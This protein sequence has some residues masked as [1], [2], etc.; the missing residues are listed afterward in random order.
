MTDSTAEAT[1]SPLAPTLAEVTANLIRDL[2]TSIEELTSEELNARPIESG[3]S[4]GFHAW[5]VLR[6]IDNIVNFVFYRDR[7]FWVTEGLHEQLDLPRIDQ[8]TGMTDEEANALHFRSA[9]DLVSYGTGVLE[10]VQPKIE[11]MDEEFLLGT[12]QTRIAGRT[13][14]RQR[15]FSLSQVVIAHG[16]EHYGQIQVLR[17]LLG[18]PSLGS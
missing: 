12:T 14:E 3:S 17:Q 11:G 1:P 5:H 18:R 13:A 9:A 15:M 10:V 8:G 7:P 2:N 4:I 16:R 6:T